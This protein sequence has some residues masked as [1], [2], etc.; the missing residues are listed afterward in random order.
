MPA[1][2][3]ATSR[4]D[5]LDYA[6]LVREV[7]SAVEQ[8]RASHD[9]TR[10][11]LDRLSSGV[12]AMI[13]ESRETRS[14]LDRLVELREDELAVR[15]EESEKR[16]QWAARLWASTPVQLLSAGVVVAILQAIGVSWVASNYLPQLQAAHAAQVSE[17][18]E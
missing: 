15:R 6:S 1:E 16:A 4:D 17:V 13:S 12:V 7:V 3:P 2:S 8:C 9:A 5:R 11:T 10:E 14:R 18:S